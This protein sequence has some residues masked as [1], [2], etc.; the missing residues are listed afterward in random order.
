MDCPPGLVFDPVRAICG[1]KTR[2]IVP[3]LSHAPTGSTFHKSE[4]DDRWVIMNRSR[5]SNANNDQ[6]GSWSQINPIVQQAPLHRTTSTQQRTPLHTIMYEE[7]SLQPN[8]NYSNQM[9]NTP[10]APFPGTSTTPNTIIYYAQPVEWE[11]NSGDIFRSPENPNY[12]PPS[13]PHGQ[14]LNRHNYSREF[15][16]TIPNNPWRPL[17]PPYDVRTSS[18]NA[19]V[20]ATH[21][22]P[23]TPSWSPHDVRTQSGNRVQSIPLAPFPNQPQTPIQHILPPSYNDDVGQLPLDEENFSTM[24]RD[25]KN[26]SSF[27]EIR[28][29]SDKV[30]I[31]DQT[32]LYG[33]LLPPL[34]CPP[35]NY[36]DLNDH[37]KQ[38][39]LP[40]VDTTPTVYT[41]VV[42]HPQLSNATIKTFSQQPHYSPSYSGV[43][44]SRNT[45]WS[46]SSTGRKIPQHSLVKPLYSNPHPNHHN[47]KNQD[48]R[49]NEGIGTTAT[50]TPRTVQGY[51]DHYYQSANTKQ[52]GN[53]NNDERLSS[54]E[55]DNQDLQINEALKLLLRPYAG[56]NDDVRDEMAERA[57]EHIMNLIK[58]TITTSTTTSTTTTT[59]IKPFVLTK[60]KNT[61]E[62][63]DVELILAGEQHNLVGPPGA[64]T[65]SI[66]NAQSEND[67][68]PNRLENEHTYIS[69]SS[70]PHHHSNWHKHH[71]K[72][73]KHRFQHRHPHH[74]REFHRIHSHL[75]NPF[76]NE[77][78]ENSDR[79]IPIIP[80]IEATTPKEEVIDLRSNSIRCPFDCGNGKC[81]Q[82][83]EVS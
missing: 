79:D 24:S 26:C 63:P 71:H 30:F 17:R 27:D 68:Q 10:L 83:H 69:S 49:N 35:Q 53:N 7:G 82:N 70:V 2:E 21:L 23:A 74:S 1:P 72:S 57:Q 6:T 19:D 44:H 55:M 40:L 58:H 64:V 47:D 39:P 67:M 37:Q 13:L 50:T 33:G 80:Q 46:N 12:P 78:P 62:Q 15:N 61:H 36:L 65:E 22:M 59:T 11:E 28:S 56:R 48:D 77:E 34:P 43:A 42:V 45:S 9:F 76:A 31:V 25:S 54:A 81:V 4:A 20:S 29:N 38:I 14:T 73:H 41:S 18:S 60:S 66:S 75:P 16:F 3:G 52:L 8:R 51:N 5:P 32:N